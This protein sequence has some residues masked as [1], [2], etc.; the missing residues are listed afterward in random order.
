[1]QCAPSIAA[2]F[3]RA[4]A[5][6]FSAIAIREDPVKVGGIGIEGEP[7]VFRPSAG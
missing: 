5:A 6:T 3:M 7:A 2:A 1:M 4:A